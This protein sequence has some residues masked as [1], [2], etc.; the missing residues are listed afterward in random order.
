[1]EARRLGGSEVGRVAK[2]RGTRGSGLGR[3][4]IAMAA[5]RRGAGVETGKV[6]N[7]MRSVRPPS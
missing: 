7:R 2:P 5:V 1:M 4:A 3:A 6:T